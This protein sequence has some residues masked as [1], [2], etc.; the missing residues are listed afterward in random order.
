MIV[1]VDLAPLGG[2]DR[3]CPIVG[4]HLAK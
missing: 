3:N 1:V 2:G 4:I